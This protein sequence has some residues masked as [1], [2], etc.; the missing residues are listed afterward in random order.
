MPLEGGELCS[1]WSINQPPGQPIGVTVHCTQHPIREQ[2]L[3]SQPSQ[4]TFLN[5][6]SRRSTEATPLGFHRPSN[7]RHAT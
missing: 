2:S 6:P 4:K 1:P 7:R 3:S 5:S